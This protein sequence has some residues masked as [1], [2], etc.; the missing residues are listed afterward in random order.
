MI[1]T[2]TIFSI[3]LDDGSL[4]QARGICKNMPLRLDI[5]LFYINC[6]VFPIS[7]PISSVDMI[8]GVSWLATFGEVQANRQKLT[9]ELTVQ[10]RTK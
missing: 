6:Y 7:S 1:E 8:L 3:I 4:V 9:M 10:G 2:T 5:E